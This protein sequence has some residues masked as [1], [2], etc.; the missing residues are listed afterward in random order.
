MKPKY[1]LLLILLAGFLVRLPLLFMTHGEPLH[2]VDE[3]HYNG[4]ALHFVQTGNFGTVEE[5]TSIRP[6]LYIWF[7]AGIYKIVGVNNPDC[8]LTIVRFIQI[9]LSLITAWLV[10]RLSKKTFQDDSAALVS[11]GIFCF[12]PSLLLQ[13]Y[14]ILTETLF[15]FWLTGTLYFAV[16]LLQKGNNTSENSAQTLSQKT[17]WLYAVFCGVCLGLG[18][19]TRSI[20]W[21]AIPYTSLYL[22]LFLQEKTLKRIL[23]GLTVLS[24]ALIIIAP[25]VIRNTKLQKTF[26]VIDCMSGRNL[27]MGNYEYTPLYRSWDAI[28]VPPPDDW[29]TVLHEHY[30]KKGIDSNPTTQ[31]QKDKMAAA[32]AKE[33][34]LAHPLQTAQRMA[35]KALCFWQLERSATALFKQGWL[36]SWLGEERTTAGITAFIVICSFVFVFFTALPGALLENATAWRT[37]L[38]Y[39][40]VTALFWGVHS[41]VFAHSRYHLPLIPVLCLYSGLYIMSL[42][43]NGF[44]IKTNQIPRAAALVLLMMIFT[45]FWTLEILWY[46]E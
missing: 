33:Y 35:V 10:Y 15:T 39:F 5:L 45:G 31:G 27:M 3:Q 26:T 16:S 11:A 37:G 6:P 46:F 40:C 24:V 32:Y 2:I 29:Y 14:L 13:N 9:A 23:T 7:V 21:L 30:S 12:Y 41:L 34:M 20:L 22:I 8:V 42:W 19:L 17:Y 25:W 44:D 28:S 36:K 4:I 38:F 1:I 43:R 18:A